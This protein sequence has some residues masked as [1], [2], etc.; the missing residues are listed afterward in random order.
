MTVGRKS[1]DD[2][3]LLEAFG[4]LSRCDLEPLVAADHGNGFLH[5]SAQGPHLQRYAGRTETN[6]PVRRSRRIRRPWRVC[7]TTPSEGG[8]GQPRHRVSTHA[9]RVNPW[10]RSG[11]RW[12]G[13]TS[14][15][16]GRLLPFPASNDS[17]RTGY[18]PDVE[19]ELDG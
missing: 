5:L 3:L 4:T 7:M 6:R 13:N 8:C 10:G 2:H 9:A 16:T 17:E 14:A 12:D 11:W 1:A 15:Q 19:R 18:Q